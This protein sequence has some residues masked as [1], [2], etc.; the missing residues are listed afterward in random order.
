M[1]TLTSAT[2]IGGDPVSLDSSEP[3]RSKVIQR[4]QAEYMEMPGLKLTL[5]QA[6][7]LFGVSAHESQRVLSELMACGFLGRDQKGAYRRQP[8]PR[9][10]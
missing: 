9:C 8:C 6:A 10:S 7:R 2:S 3:M 1:T 5:P 4:I